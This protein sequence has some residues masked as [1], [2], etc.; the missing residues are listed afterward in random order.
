M[1]QTTVCKDCGQPMET[2]QQEQRQ[3]PPITIVTCKNRD[4]SLYSVTLSTDQYEKLTEIQLDGYRKMVAQF[5][6]RH[7]RGG[8]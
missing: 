2:H 3:A 8:E 6:E 7:E 1:Q 4:C 5:K